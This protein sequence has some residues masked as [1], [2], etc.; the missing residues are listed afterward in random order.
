MMSDAMYVQYLLKD[1]KG[2]RR[3][4]DLV[5]PTKSIEERYSRQERDIGY[6]S[7]VELKAYNSIIPTLKEI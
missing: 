5:I 4:Y 1:K 2:C 3:M 7:A 6:I